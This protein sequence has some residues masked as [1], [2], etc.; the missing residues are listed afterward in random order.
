MCPLPIGLSA[1][2]PLSLRHKTL[3]IKSRLGTL[4]AVRDITV[5]DY[6]REAADPVIAQAA[7]SSTALRPMAILGMLKDIYSFQS[8]ATADPLTS[9][10]APQTDQFSRVTTITTTS[11]LMARASALVNEQ[12]GGGFPPSGAA[13]GAATPAM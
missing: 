3:L 10:I 4:P 7:Q 8:A 5:A 1:P 12:Q 9:V 6:V 13:G 2:V 11:H